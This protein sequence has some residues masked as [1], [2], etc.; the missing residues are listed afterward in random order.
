MKKIKE[1]YEHSRRYFYLNKESDF[2]GYYGEK[3]KIL[4][5]Y[6]K[7]KYEIILYPLLFKIKEQRT[8]T[9]QQ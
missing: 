7:M 8:I 9:M 2:V 4:K 3:P 1:Y 5:I 6:K